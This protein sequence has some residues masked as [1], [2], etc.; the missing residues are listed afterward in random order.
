MKPKGFYRLKKQYPFA[1]TRL[2]VVNVT[3]S[4]RFYLWVEIWNI[5]IFPLCETG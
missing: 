5:V 1:F 4:F 2:S 3:V